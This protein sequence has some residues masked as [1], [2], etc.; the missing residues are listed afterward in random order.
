MLTRV[1][2]AVKE[3]IAYVSSV[4]PSSELSEEEKESECRPARSAV[5][6]ALSVV[7]FAYLYE[8]RFLLSAM[9]IVILLIGN[10]RLPAISHSTLESLGKN[11][12][13]WC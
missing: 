10:D 1:I 12:F 8:P 6:Q 7:W 13:S 4:S 11:K 3:K 9:E 2:D 5:Y